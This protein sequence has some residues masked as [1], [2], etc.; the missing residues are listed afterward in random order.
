MN[1]IINSKFIQLIWWI[2]TPLLIA[3][4]LISFSMF[5]LDNQKLKDLHVEDEK[6]SYMYGFPKISHAVSTKKEV[7][8]QKEKVEKLDNLTLSACYIE[9][10]GE[11]IIANENKKTFFIN[12][13]EEYKG[14]KLTKITINSAT[15]LKDGRYID[16]TIAK[17]KS[18]DK[19]KSIFIKKSASVDDSYVSV[20]RDEITKY[21][22]NIKRV[23][24]D[25]RFQEAKID[26]KFIG[27]RLNFI[28]K[29]SLFDKMGLKRDDTII[30]VDNKELGSMMDLLPYYR[31]L[32][33]ITTI[34]V[35]IKRKEEIKEIVYE[36]N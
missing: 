27:V 19:I 36:I 35:E 3:K 18:K 31:S 1:L 32:S 20:K 4:L 10:D 21:T 28:R 5:F 8:I 34:Q 22:K 6:N 23:L 15:F 11:F 24:K 9:K 17:S 13:G 12:L 29:G 2:F 26:K 16:L 7:K 14:A 25:I 30:S 33:N